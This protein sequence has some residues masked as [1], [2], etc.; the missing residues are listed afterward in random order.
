MDICLIFSGQ[1]TFS[2]FIIYNLLP[3]GEGVYKEDSCQA[4][5]INGIICW[6]MLSPKSLPSLYGPPANQWCYGEGVYR[7]RCCSTSP[8]LAVLRNCESHHVT[9][10]FCKAGDVMQ[11]DEDAVWCVLLQQARKNLCHQ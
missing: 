8:P 11:H 3:S 4:S 10:H 1:I 2:S 5:Q 6:C 7:Q 9:S